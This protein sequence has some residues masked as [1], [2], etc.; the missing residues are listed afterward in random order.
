MKFRGMKA[1]M[2][3]D[4][5][6]VIMMFVGLIFILI[7]GCFREGGFE[8][9]YEIAYNRGRI[10]FLELNPDPRIRHSFWSVTIGS[11]FTWLYTYG[12]NQ[13]QVQRGLSC[14]NMTTARIAY[15]VN[16]PGLILTMLIPALCGILAFARYSD[17]DPV[18]S[19]IVTKRDQL[20]VLYVMDIVAEDAPGL[21]GLF[22]A[23]L[24]SAALST[25][26]SGINGLAAVTCKDFGV[27][28]FLHSRGWT[29]VAIT[30]IAKLISAL[31]GALCIVM[32]FPIQNLPGLLDS[33]LALFGALGGPLLGAFIC[34]IFVPI[35]N[36]IGVLAGMIISA[37]TTIWLTLGSKIVKH[38]SEAQAL[39]SSSIRMCDWNHYGTL[40][41]KNEPLFREPRYLNFEELS[42]LE[43]FYSISYLYIGIIGI[44]LVLVVSLVTSAAT[45]F[46]HM[47]DEEAEKLLHPVVLWIT[48]MRRL[49]SATQTEKNASKE[50]TEL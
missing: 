32:I 47:E 33:A 13:A 49:P 25:V 3:T 38:V 40:F 39:P 28:Y 41:P 18:R 16:V 31:Y 2:W 5:F 4:A 43:H 6:Q 20:L 37:A 27:Q 45:G 35:I 30:K 12:V 23:S 26:S 15:W 44:T 11:V 10:Q 14:R 1:T 22:M 9:A 29:D 50:E 7:V 48:G 46:N 19:K 8:N 36:H 21:P 34:G 42:G 24:F 17:C